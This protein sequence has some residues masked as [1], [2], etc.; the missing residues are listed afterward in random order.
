ASDRPVATG[1]LAKT[2]TF[3]RASSLLFGCCFG[4]GCL[5]GRRV[6]GFGGSSALGGFFFG[7]VLCFLAGLGFLPVGALFLF[8]DASGL[9]H[10]RNTVGRLRALVQPVLD[11]LNA[12]LDALFA[13]LGQKRA[14]GAELFDKA[15]VARHAAVGG[16]DAVMGAFLAAAASETNLHGHGGI[17]LGV[18]FRIGAVY[19]A[20]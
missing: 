4:F 2:E 17:S 12:H 6:G 14:I 13:V 15:A 9:Q 5:F 11:A 20:E 16:D 3:Q 1:S 10:T 19:G 8:D 18:C 7:T